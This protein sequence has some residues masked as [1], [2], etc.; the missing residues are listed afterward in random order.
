MR[1]LKEFLI[2][3]TLAIICFGAKDSSDC[4][5]TITTQCPFGEFCDQ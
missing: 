2:L 3:V 5:P 1:F 4:D